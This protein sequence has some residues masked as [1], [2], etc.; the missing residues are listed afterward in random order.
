M[1]GVKVNLLFV[2]GGMEWPPIANDLYNVCDLCVFFC[3]NQFMFNVVVRKKPHTSLDAH[4]TCYW[5]RGSHSPTEAG[6]SYQRDI[7]FSV[8]IIL[9]NLWKLLRQPEGP[10]YTTSQ[11]SNAVSNQPSPLRAGHHERGICHKNSILFV[12]E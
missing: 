4:E 3:H 5:D 2:H 9:T 7:D 12:T 1:P 6:R 8:L 10:F 11:F